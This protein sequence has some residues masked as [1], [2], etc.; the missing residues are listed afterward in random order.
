MAGW[1]RVAWMTGLLAGLGRGVRV[2]ARPVKAWVW[3][4]RTPRPELS[5]ET[6]YYP[7]RGERGVVFL[8]RDEYLQE[9]EDLLFDTDP[10]RR[11]L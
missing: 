7:A 11:S 8:P 9:V 6:S 2:W 5:L 10:T 1:W 3:E 4:Q